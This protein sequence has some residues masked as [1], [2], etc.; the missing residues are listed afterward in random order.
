[1]KRGP[2]L[3]LKVQSKSS[4]F[5]QEIWLRPTTCMTANSKRRGMC[6]WSQQRTHGTSSTL[7][8]IS[9]NSNTWQNPHHRL[10]RLEASQVAEISPTDDSILAPA[11]R[12][13]R[14]FASCVS[15]PAIIL[16]LGGWT[17]TTTSDRNALDVHFDSI[18]NYAIFL[19]NFLI[20]FNFHNLLNHQFK[21][22]ISFL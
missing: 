2:E 12:P 3:F 8:I 4:K 20:I 14:F 15:Y 6:F 9:G 11:H 7:G 18:I 13:N 16:S 21:H 5:G 17:S 22:L 1:M 19:H 10:T